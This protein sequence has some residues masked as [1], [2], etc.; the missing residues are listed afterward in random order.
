MGRGATHQ[1]RHHAPTHSHPNSRLSK[2]DRHRL[3]IQHLEQGRTLEELAL[4]NCVILR[5]AHR[6]LSRYRL[7]GAAFLAES[8]SMRL[9]QRPTLDP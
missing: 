2:R 7:S 8:P 5:F 4:E 9:T 6:W 1:P 3:V